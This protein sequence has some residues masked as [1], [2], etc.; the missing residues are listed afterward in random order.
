[1]RLIVC[2]ATATF[3][4]VGLVGWAFGFG[5][6]GIMLALL[7]EMLMSLNSR[8][9]LLNWFEIHTYGVRPGN[10]PA[11]PRSTCLPFPR[12]SQAKPRRGD[13]CIG[14]GTTFVARPKS[15]TVSGFAPGVELNRGRSTRMPPVIVRCALTRQ[16]SPAYAPN[17]A[18]RKSASCC[19]LPVFE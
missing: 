11:P 7:V 1:M 15:V 9:L 4:P 10:T 18:T 17:C 13:H 2:F 3:A 19:G 14:D 6:N 8:P 12:G 16:T 5:L